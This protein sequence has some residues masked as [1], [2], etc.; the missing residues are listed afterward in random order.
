[1]ASE[2]VDPIDWSHSPPYTGQYP[3]SS[4]Y[5]TVQCWLQITR[6][7]ALTEMRTCDLRN[8]RPTHCLCGNSEHCTIRV[9]AS[10]ALHTPSTR[11]T[12]TTH[13]KY[14]LQTHCTLRVHASH[15]VHTPSTRF[16]LCAHSEYKLHRHCTL[17][18]WASH[19][20][21]TPST[22]FTGTAHSEYKLH[23][24]CTHRVQA[25]HSVHT[26]STR[27]NAVDTLSTRFT[28][29]MCSSVDQ[30]S[31][32]CSNRNRLGYLRRHSENIFQHNSLR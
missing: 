2:T 10:H 29:F 17:R 23:T 4:M 3:L 30:W 12:L 31:T 26:S 20:V 1:M 22:S 7:T 18:V 32:D 25:S 6:F 13:S 16:T 5:C 14:K 28:L 11:F 21:H 19:S 15:S 9:H 24:H 27:F 8:A